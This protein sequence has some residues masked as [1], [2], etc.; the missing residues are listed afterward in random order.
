MMTSRKIV[1]AFALGSIC[2]VGA[3]YVVNEVRAAGVPS[4]SPLVY[5]GVLEQDGAPVDGAFEISLVLWD[6]DSG[7]NSLCETTP[8][9]P[10]MVENGSFQISLDASCADAFAEHSDVWLQ[11]VVN[12]DSLGRTKVNAV[13]YALEANN[14]LR[15]GSFD[16]SLLQQVKDKLDEQPVITRYEVRS[17]LSTTTGNVT[18]VFVD[19][20]GEQ[21]QLGVPGAGADISNDRICYRGE[22]SSDARVFFNLGQDPG[23][24]SLFPS[25]YSPTTEGYVPT[26]PFGDLRLARGKMVNHPAVQCFDESVEVFGVSTEGESGARALPVHNVFEIVCIK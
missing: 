17:V 23:A 21:H 9:S 16:E 15:V 13:P 26:F 11:V 18:V 4:D 5:S 6:A 19:E 8:G 10:T 7:G 20:F 3:T 1:F 2:A 24:C 22:G 25:K 14:A 12:G